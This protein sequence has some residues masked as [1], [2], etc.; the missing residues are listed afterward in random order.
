MLIE[1][2][3]D[4]FFILQWLDDF[5]VGH[6]GFIAGGCFK[7]IFNGEPVK[8]LD[9]FFRSSDDYAEAE[10]QFDSLCGEDNKGNEYRFY[11]ESKN[12]KAYKHIKTGVTVELISKVYGT[13]EEIV[14]NFD[15]TI[16]KFAYYAEEV[17]DDDPIFAPDDGEQQTRIE[18]KILHHENYFEHLHLKRLV[19]DDKITYPA[20]TFERMIRYVGY[21]YKPCKETKLKIMGAINASAPTEIEVVESLYDGMD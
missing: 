15:F 5:L 7:N 3:K 16:S 8:D 6:N 4:N 14:G 13:P 17:P 10:E 2:D 18:H 21:G 19:T 9:V 1:R 11:Y 12:V 20:S